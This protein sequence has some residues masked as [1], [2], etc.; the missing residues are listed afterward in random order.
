MIGADAYR[1]IQELESEAA[2]LGFVVGYTV[3]SYS[4]NKLSLRPRVD[5]DG[6]EHLPAFCSDADILYGSVEE[7]LASLQGWVK[8]L[9]YLRVINAV[10]T[11]K[12]QKKE[13][14]FRN[15]K[16]LKQL[17]QAEDSEKK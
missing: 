10:T 1:K 4:T 13:Q 15:R 9:D 16:L 2:R 7:L 12:I 14:D 11:Q 3:N 5:E 8:C 6:F 17:A